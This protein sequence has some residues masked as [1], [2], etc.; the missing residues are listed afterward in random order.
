MSVSNGWSFLPVGEIIWFVQQT[1]MFMNQRKLCI[2][3]T[4]TY[5]TRPPARTPHAVRSAVS[6]DCSQGIRGACCSRC[7]EQTADMEREQ[8]VPGRSCCGSPLSGLRAVTAFATA[9]EGVRRGGCEG[10]KLPATMMER[11]RRHSRRRALKG[12]LGVS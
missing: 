2:A 4:E 5:T 1:M 7:A 3:F 11:P 6:I 9:V 8:G 12:F 10:W